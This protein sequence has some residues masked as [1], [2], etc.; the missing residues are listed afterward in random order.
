MSLRRRMENELERD[1]REHIEMETRENVERGMSP[2]AARFTALRKFGNVALAAEDTRAVWRWMWLDRTLQ[3]ARH[4][5]RNLRRNP[6]FAAV[7]I[8]TL[9]LAIGMNAAVFSVV[10]AALIKPLPYP[11]PSRLMW[12][13]MYAP[14]LH[15]EASSAPDFS[16]WRSQARSFEKMAGYGS[17]DSTVQDGVESFKHSFVWTTPEFWSIA[18]A[19]AAV[20]RL[21]SERDRN[22]VVLTWRMFE[23]RFAGDSRVLGKTVLVDGRSTTI[24]GVLPKDFRFLPPGATQGIDGGMSGE[25][26]AFTPVVLTP[27]MQRHG[28]P[29]LIMFV[30][31]RLKPGVSR[32]QALAELKNIQARTVEQNPLMRGFYTAWEMRVTPLKEKLV[33]ESRRALLVLLAAVGFVLLIA[34]GNLGN[35]LLARATARQREIAIRAALGAS[36]GRLLRYFTAEALALALPGAIAGLALARAADRLLVRL[37]PSAVPRIGEVA[38]DWRVAAFTIAISLLAAIVFASVPVLSLPA[39]SLY[40]V[41]KDGG[42]ASGSRRALR[43]RRVLVAGELALALVL[44]TGAGL[45]VK[46]FARMYAHPASFEPEKIGV[47]KVYLTG[48]AYRDSERGA[49]ISYAQRV[50]DRASAV[51]GVETV[52]LTNITGRGLADIVGP[53]RFPPGEAPQIVIRAASSGYPRLLGI[54]LLKGRLTADNESE[55]VVMVNRTFAARVFGRENPLGQRVRVQ[56]VPAAIVGVVG[57]LKASR[58]DADPELEV[59]VPFKQTL[60]FRR[61]DVLFKSHNEP[62]A[63]LPEVRKAIQRID[64]T[65]PPYGLTTLESTLDESIA[66]RRFNLLLLGIFASGAVLLA[67]VGIYGVISYSVAQRTQEIGVRMALGARR[68]EIARMVIRHGMSA[69][70]AGIVAGILAALALTRLMAALLFEVRPNDAPTFAAVAAALTVTALLACWLPA[71][72]AARVDPTTALRYE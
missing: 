72:K 25:A 16:D 42:R 38:I 68:T 61:L 66:P 49:A 1:I 23:Q 71:R 45:M 11:G 31:G 37:S 47:A 70:L 43:L 24:I 69:A 33:G 12:L 41:L 52:A 3:D 58:L 17:V 36:R 27:D 57:D 9:A 13:A 5:L 62:A 60:I 28:G 51:P 32:V 21:F 14:R 26:E 6:A 30:V 10:S 48:P 55:P 53:P 67:L 50:L 35:L 40:S 44:L 19:H 39:G 22:V 54:P 46:S 29:A 2:D 63:L 8:L 15:F 20:G 4:A 56:G 34:C 18:G 65:Q 7:S 64:P 59:F